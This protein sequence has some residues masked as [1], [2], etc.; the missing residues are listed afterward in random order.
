MAQAVA[1]HA[2]HH[3]LTYV[4]AERGIARDAGGTIADGMLPMTPLELS[5]AILALLLTPGPTNTLLFVAGSERGWSRALR[6][7]PAEIAGYLSVTVPLAI[8][9]GQLVASVPALRPAIA[10]LAGLWVAYLALRL[11]RLPD[12]A[13]GGAQAV[14]A[15]SVLV[16]TMLNPKAL[17]F[18]LVLLPSPTQLTFNILL[19]ATQIALVASA[20]SGL[21]A[22]LSARDSRGQGLPLMRRAAALWLAVV[23]V[24][25]IAKGLQA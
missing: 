24:S 8:A 6:L 13:S 20:W 1:L 25:L 23:S 15:R 11:W 2:W 18:G 21:G 5:F 9:G 14:S 19:F 10:V 16:T 22:A 3:T 17:I 4:I 7:I 12:P